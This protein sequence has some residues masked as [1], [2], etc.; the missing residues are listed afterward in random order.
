MLYPLPRKSQQCNE[1]YF[2]KYKKYKNKIIYIS[3][4][5]KYNS[6]LSYSFKHRLNLTKDYEIFKN[7]LSDAPTGESYDE[8]EGGLDALGQVMACKE[9]IGWRKQSR[10]IIVFLTD[11][12]YHATS[13]G[14]LAGITKPYDGKCYT[15]NGVYLNELKMD[16]P[17]VGIIDKLARDEQFVIVFAVQEAKQS[18]YKKLSNSVRDSWSTTYDSTDMADILKKIYEVNY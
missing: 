1:L 17:S 6:E 12:N 15:S 10:K 9:Q 13:D 11:G 2:N 7:A 3:C 14:K 8:P 5:R 18:V 4:C 16:Y